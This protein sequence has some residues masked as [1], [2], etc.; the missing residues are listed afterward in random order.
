MRSLDETDLEILRLLAENGRRPYSDIAELVGLSPPAVSDRVNRLKEHGVI[1]RFTVDIDR[2]QLRNGTSVLV[3]LIVVP[4]H[5]DAVQQTLTEL[6]A[7]EHVFT[8]AN[9]NIVFY[10]MAPRTDVRGWLL[11]KINTDIIRELEVELVSDVDWNLNVGGTAFALTCAECGNTVTEE[12]VTTRLDGDLKQF[13]CSS[14]ESR[15]IERYKE[16]EE[17]A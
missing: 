9:T 8:T 5:A 3:R 10:A 1:R 7:V 13:C 15:Y 2:S 11:S 12:G 6:D 16:L 14:C 17:A 4:G